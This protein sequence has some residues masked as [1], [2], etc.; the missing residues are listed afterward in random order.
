[1][2]NRSIVC[3]F[4]CLL[5]QKEKGERKGKTEKKV[6]KKRKKKKIARAR[7]LGRAAILCV[8]RAC[9]SFFFTPRSTALKQFHGTARTFVGLLGCPC[10]SA[11]V[12]S[13]KCE[14]REHDFL[15]QEGFPSIQITWRAVAAACLRFGFGFRLRLVQAKYTT[16]SLDAGTV[17]THKNSCGG[18][19]S[20]A[21]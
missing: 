14:Q 13:R 9:F 16:P 4:V 12:R 20:Y 18:Y 19:R 11:C 15:L 1:M 21:K 6:K 3:L 8:R 7:V 2:K 5:C 17:Y 10:S